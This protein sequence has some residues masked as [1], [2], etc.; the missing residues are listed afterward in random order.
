M[1]NYELLNTLS[2]IHRTG[3][4]KN[5]AI[6]I[7]VLAVISIG[8]IIYIQYLRKGAENNLAFQKSKHLNLLQE[9]SMLIQSLQNQINNLNLSKNKE[10][11]Q[12]G[13]D[14]LV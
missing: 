9:N 1:N 10:N 14:A 2:Q 5:G 11:V 4:N 12:L 13:N 6:I 7:G 3:S 8:G